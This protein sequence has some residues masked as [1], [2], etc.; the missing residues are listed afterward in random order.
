[1]NGP[2]SVHSHN[3]QNKIID[4]F[5]LIGCSA[6]AIAQTIQKLSSV[7]IALAYSK[8][9]TRFEPVNEVSPDAGQ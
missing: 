4:K 3:C 5:N 6:A 8:W 1:M 2:R 9:A 7:R